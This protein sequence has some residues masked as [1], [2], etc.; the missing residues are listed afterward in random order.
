MAGVRSPEGAGRVDG[1]DVILVLV[2]LAR[3][4]VSEDVVPPEADCAIGRRGVAGSAVSARPPI[5]AVEVVPQDVGV[6]IRL[7]TLPWAYTRSRC[8]MMSPVTI[9]TI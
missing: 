1:G 2:A 8:H 4:D 7:P 6:F 9:M 5:V 3:I